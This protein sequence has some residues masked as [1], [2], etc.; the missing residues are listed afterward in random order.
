MSLIIVEQDIACAK[1]F[2]SFT[3]SAADIEDL[4][5]SQRLVFLE[6]LQNFDSPLPVERVRLLGA[7]YDLLSSKNFELKVAYYRI[8]LAAGDES[9]YRGVADLLGHVGRMKLVRPLFRGLNKV[10]RKLAV[11]TFEKNKE[12]YHPICKAMVAKDLGLS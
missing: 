10:D 9:C 6:T 2:Q 5:G 11:E 1:P 12:F 7:T 8:A 4:N 3:P